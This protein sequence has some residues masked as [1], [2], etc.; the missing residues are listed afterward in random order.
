MVAPAPLAARVNGQPITSDAFAAEVERHMVR[1]STGGHQLPASIELRV[2][3]RVLR[4]MIETTLV[5]QKAEEL[6]LEV[7]DADLRAALADRERP[8]AR[9]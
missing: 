1:Y 3:E 7:T 5:A 9:D 4:D 2:R 8:D 6:R